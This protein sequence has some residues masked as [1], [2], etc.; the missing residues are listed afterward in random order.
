MKP[1]KILQSCQKYVFLVCTCIGVLVIAILVADH[2]KWDQSNMSAHEQGMWCFGIQTCILVR[3][4]K[5]QLLLHETK[6]KIGATS[7][8]F[9]FVVASVFAL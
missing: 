9:V 7:R 1:T 2:V 3:M 6:T 4:P 8:F 5:Q